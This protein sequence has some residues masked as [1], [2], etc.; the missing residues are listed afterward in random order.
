[1]RLFSFDGV[2]GGEMVSVRVCA[3]G[4]GD[5]VLVRSLDFDF[6]GVAVPRFF[7]MTDNVCFEPE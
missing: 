4:V 1:M 6:V 3:N 5:A 7:R 2:G